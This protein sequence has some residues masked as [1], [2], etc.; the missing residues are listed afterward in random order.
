MFLLDQCQLSTHIALL[1]FWYLQAYKE[2]LVSRPFSRSYRICRRVFN[3][4]RDILFADEQTLEAIQR[5]RNRVRENTFPALIGMSC[6]MAAVAAPQL[7]QPAGQMA[8]VQGRKVRSYRDPAKTATAS[9]TSHHHLVV[10][11]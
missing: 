6:V 9:S 1:T 4:V 3:R 11:L 8:V 2:D 10:G 7:L 5:R